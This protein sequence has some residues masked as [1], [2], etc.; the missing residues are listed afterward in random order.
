M[1]TNVLRR[2]GAG[3]GL[4]A[5]SLL[6]ACGPAEEAPKDSVT[7]GLLLPFTGTNSATTSNFE[8]AALFASARIN[9]GGGINGRPLRL[10]SKD[11]HSD[12]GA[13]QSLARRV[14]GRRRGSGRWP[15]K[16]RHCLGD[17][18]NLGCARSGLSVA[19]GRRRG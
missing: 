8:R 10:L 1:R 4:L 2:L 6:V 19:L 3:L 5:T 12:F 9:A 13:R 18:P 11:T 15:R 14:G 7:V 17:R 16:R